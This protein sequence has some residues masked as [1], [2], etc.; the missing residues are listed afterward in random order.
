MLAS[1][2]FGGGFNAGVT[3][4]GTFF[5]QSYGSIT[6]GVGAFAGV[7]VNYGVGRG[8]PLSSGTSSAGQVE[9]NAGWL[10]SLGGTLTADGEGNWGLAASPHVNRGFGF[11]AELAAGPV[12]TDTHVSRV[13]PIVKAIAKHL[14]F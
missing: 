14:C 13:F 4:S 10:R 8:S 6:G 1:V 5:F 3:S 12:A 7:S 9:I 2:F 11:G